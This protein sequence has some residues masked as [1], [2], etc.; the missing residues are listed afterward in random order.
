MLRV[1]SVAS[2]AAGRARSAAED[3]DEKEPRGLPTALDSIICDE[4]GLRSDS[5]SVTKV[6]GGPWISCVISC[7]DSK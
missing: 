4:V 6:D 5:K 1:V 7:G 3:A 2:R